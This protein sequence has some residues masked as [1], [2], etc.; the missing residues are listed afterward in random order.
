MPHSAGA[1][2]MKVLEALLLAEGYLQRHGVESARLSAE[3]LLAKRMGCSRLDVY[4]RFDQELAGDMLSSYREDL[5]VRAKHYPLQYILGEIEFMSL[6]FKV[7]EG[8]F[9]PRPETE[10]LVEWIEELAGSLPSASFVEFGVGAGVVSGSLCRRHPGWSGRAIDVSAD[11]VALARE[12]FEA[13]G[14]AD[15]MDV[16]AASDLGRIE[17]ERSLDLLVAN[18]PYIPTAAIDGLDAE[19]SRYEARAALDGGV[20][21]IDF[22]SVLVRDAARL[23]GP[24]GIA[25]FEIGHAQGDAVLGI[26]AAG[27]LVRSSMRK[28]YNG[29]E[30]MVTAF[31]PDS[32]G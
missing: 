29:F 13:L 26:C 25:A 32:G 20:D 1:K 27:G 7:R 31:A 30:R 10:L 19:V 2:T 21:G 6:P 23:L 18:P 8:V 9:I 14:V 22:Y 3:H 12:N 4:L 5:K 17:G 28:D 11:A 16:F 15:R 24:G